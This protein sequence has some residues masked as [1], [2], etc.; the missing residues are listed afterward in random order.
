MHYTSG[1][2]CI[3]TSTEGCFS[4]YVSDK[5]L[6]RLKLVVSKDGTELTYDLK[7]DGT[8]EVFPLQ[9][10]DGQYEIALYEN[11]SGNKYCN[12]G[13]IYL[14]NKMKDPNS[15]FLKPNQYVNYGQDDDVVAKAHELCGDDIKSSYEAICKY[16]RTSFAYD[17]IKAVTV[18]PGMLPDIGKSFAKH[19]GICQDLAGITVAMMRSCGIPSRLVI[20]WADKNYHAWVETFIDGVWKRFDPTFEVKASGKVKKYTPERYY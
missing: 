2:L 11:V 19:M 5:V 3:D 4:A 9:L 7:N 6:K 13:T 18:K 20:G 10:G 8:R 15:P 17:Y 16:I 14:S 1:R 12:G